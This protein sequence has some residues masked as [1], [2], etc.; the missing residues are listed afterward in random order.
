ME[1]VLYLVGGQDPFGRAQEIESV[2]ARWPTVK[3]TL[4]ASAEVFSCTSVD[5]QARMLALDI[6][7]REQGIHVLRLSPGCLC[8]S[9]KLVLFTH[10][11]RTLRLSQPDVLILELDS[12]SH[13]AEVKKLLQEPQW[14]TWFSV[15]HE[16]GSE[17]KA[18]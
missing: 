15:I 17:Q 14:Q 18:E 12:Q 4:L 7:K 1:T 9:S 3:R 8:C 16:G 2:L 6:A 5:E 11:G 13:I 10:I